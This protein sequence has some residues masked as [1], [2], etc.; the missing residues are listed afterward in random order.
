M[1]TP[2]VVV[3]AMVFGL[4][5]GVSF[6]VVLRAAMDRGAEALDVQASSLPDGAAAVVAALVEP[7]VVVDGS[8]TVLQATEPAIAMGLVLGQAVAHP[9]LDRL[10]D[11]ARSDHAPR[12]AD[13]SLPRAASGPR[14]LLVTAHAAPLDVGRVLLVVEDR[15]DAARLDAM[16]RDFVANVSHEL[17]TP[18]GAVS[19][20]S[21]ALVTAADDPER[22]RRFAGRLT[23]EAARLAALVQEILTFS[24]LQDGD[25]LQDAALVSL[26]E[27]LATAV[28]RTRVAAEAHSVG[29]VVG[30]RSG[31]QVLGDAAQLTTAVQNLV[32]NAIAFSPA[33]G[34][35]GIGVRARD[36]RVEIAVSDQG[37]GIPQEDQER[38]FERFYRTDQ[39][40]SRQT[41][42]TGLGLSIVKH[43]AENHGGDVRLWSQPGR[44]STFTVR[45]PEA[46][47][48]E[49]VAVRPKRREKERT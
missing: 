12:Q 22:V 7:V 6:T 49:P 17:K 46:P 32:A 39:A 9:E 26:D 40:R 42:G 21:E 5:V 47:A 3:L 24:R 31:L 11:D 18:I 8:N 16:R 41:G 36:G 1:S 30:K 2:D 33:G 37:C 14:T 10:I 13:L 4:V 15:S 38:V 44:G 34:H 20:L 25:P 19:L 29:V 28:D 23:T 27:V 45:L 35:V 48:P 43:V